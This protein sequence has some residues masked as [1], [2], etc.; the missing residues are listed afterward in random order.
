MGDATLVLKLGV[1]KSVRAL[2]GPKAAW[3]M[4]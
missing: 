4:V 1:A 3:T 2:M